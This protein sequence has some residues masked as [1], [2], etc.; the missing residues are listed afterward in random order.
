MGRDDRCERTTSNTSRFDRGVGK[1][2]P[3]RSEST[4]FGQRNKRAGPSF[5]VRLLQTVGSE[6]LLS[7]EKQMA[8]VKYNFKY[9]VAAAV[10]ALAL[11]S[12]SFANAQDT[13]VATE[14]TGPNR[15]M[16]HSGIVVF[17]LSYVPSLIVASTNSRSDDDYLYIPVAGPWLDLGHREPCVSCGNESLNKTLLVFDGIFQGVGALEVVGSFLFVETRVAATAK[18]NPKRETARRIPM[19]IT[20]AYMNGGYGI[21]AAGDF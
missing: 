16:L 8:L 18:R 4:V 5:V 6:G 17:G 3:A 11:G 14:T 12:P 21:M 20:P 2:V 10:A 15:A 7:T 1:N 19:S 13:P 9:T